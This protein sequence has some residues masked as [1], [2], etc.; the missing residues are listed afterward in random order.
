MSE[1]PNDEAREH[2][3]TEEKIRQAVERGDVP[4]AS[5]FWLLGSLVAAC[6]S[7]VL[8]GLLANQ[9]RIGG[10]GRLLELSG[11]I[12]LNQGGDVEALAF[13]TMRLADNTPAPTERVQS[14]HDLPVSEGRKR[15]LEGLAQADRYLMELH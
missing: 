5:E 7:L 14:E 3:P 4:V 13:E 11:A 2:E 9:A 1:A 8:I 12:A 10:L 6:V 15:L